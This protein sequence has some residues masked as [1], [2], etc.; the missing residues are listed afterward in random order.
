M[1]RSSSKAALLAAD[2]AFVFAFRV[3]IIELP[4]VLD[5]RTEA[6]YLRHDIYGG[7]ESRL[8][9]HARKKDVGKSVVESPYL[10]RRNA[11]QRFPP[12]RSLE[13][14]SSRHCCPGIRPRKHT[15]GLA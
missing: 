7:A 10:F 2:M 12:L 3:K 11:R 6:V 15:P 14:E 4:V 13:K 5:E 9:L 1:M 8:A